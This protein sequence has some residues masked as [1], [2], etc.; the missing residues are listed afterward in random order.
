LYKI[1]NISKFITTL[2]AKNTKIMDKRTFIKTGSLLT[3]ATILAPVSACSTTKAVA[4]TSI[5]EFALPPLSYSLEALEPHFDKMTMEIHHGRHH[6]TYVQRLNEAIKNS[7]FASMT[8]AEMMNK[9]TDKDGAIRN[10]G[11]GHYNHSLFWSILSPKGGTPTGKLSESL[12]ST[13]GSIDKFK[14]MFNDAAK[15]VFGSGWTWLSVGKDK[16][17]FISTTPNQ[18]NPLMTNIVK[19]VGTPILGLDVWE[20]AYYLKYQNK[21]ADYITA[22]WNVVNWDEVSKQFVKVIG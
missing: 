21:R 4:S 6:A 7:P 9:I 19:Q 22:F 8:L 10:N 11:G 5:G 14:T 2:A 20:H 18:D 3:A 16:K 1:I 12:E 15:T 17:L 13:F